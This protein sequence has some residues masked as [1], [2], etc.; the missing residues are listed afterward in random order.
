MK[1]LR[2]H[3]YVGEEVMLGIRPE[4]IHDEPVFIESSQ[5]TA[6][7]ANIDVAELMGAETYL[8]TSIND[9][10][11]IARIDSRTDISSGQQMKLALDMN[12]AHFFDIESELR[13]R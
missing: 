12:K 1:P 9:N 4:D 10:E 11:I 5:D 2:Q 7:D 8:Y 13:I 6:F 3:G